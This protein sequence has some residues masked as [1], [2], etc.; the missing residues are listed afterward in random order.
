MNKKFLKTLLLG[1]LMFSFMGVFTACE[2][3][4]DE[5]NNLQNQITANSDA[6]ADIQALLAKGVVIEKVEKNAEGILLTLSDG[7]TQQ[8]TNGANG[9]DGKDAAVWTIGNDGYWY[10]D[11]VK[12]EYKA[13]GTDGKDGQDGQDGKDGQD[14]NDGKDGNDGAMGDKGDVYV[15]NEDGYFHLNGEKTDI[16]WATAGVSAAQTETAV[17]IT[18]A[19][20]TKVTISTVADLK[21]MVFVPQVVVDGVNGI[22]AGALTFNDNIIC[23]PNVTAQYHLNPSSVKETGIDTESLSYVLLTKD[24]LSTRA[25]SNVTATYKEVKDGVLTV[26]VDFNGTPSTGSKIDLIALQAVN[27]AGATITSDY[28]TVATDPIKAEDFYISRKSIIVRDGDNAHFWEGAQKN[29][30]QTAS[31]NAAKAAAITEAAAAT[32]L[33][34]STDDRIITVA[35][36]KTINLNDYVGLCLKSDNNHSVFS[37][38]SD[39]HLNFRYSLV[40]RFIIGGEAGLKVETD[41]QKF[42]KLDGDKV[43]PTTYTDGDNLRSSIGRTPIVKVELLHENTV[44]KTAYIVIEIVDNGPTPIDPEKWT[45]A[46]Y[47]IVLANEGSNPGYFGYTA[48]ICDD[49]ANQITAQN[50]NSVYSGEEV[51]KEEFA[52]NYTFVPNGTRYT[53]EGVTYE[54]SPVVAYSANAGQEATYGLTWTLTAEYIWDNAGVLTPKAQAVYKHNTLNHIVVLNLEANRVIPAIKTVDLNIPGKKFNEMWN[55]D[56]TLGLFNVRVPNV[57]ENTT[58]NCTFIN[59][60]KSLYLEENGVSQDPVTLIQ[61]AFDASVYGSF[62]STIEY[63]FK[64]ATVDTRRNGHFDVE[65]NGK[66]LVWIQGLEKHLIATLNGSEVTLNNAHADTDGDGAVDNFV[67]EEFLNT[68]TLTVTYT[69][70]TSMTTCLKDANG[71]E[72]VMPIPAKDQKIIEINVRYVRPINVNEEAA[73]AFQDGEDFG[74]PG[75]ILEAADVIS[76]VDW[77][78]KAVIYNNMYYGYYGVQRVT[79][80]NSG[81]T[82]DIEAGENRPLPSTI[83]AGIVDAAALADPDLASGLTGLTIDEYFYYKN[84]G[85]VLQDDI[86]INFPVVVTYWWGEVEAGTV[87]VTVKKTKNI[88]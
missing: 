78:G 37:Q 54:T 67:A 28:H 12:T 65:N 52:A 20:G 22:W 27:A 13:V 56:L 41:Q 6:I 45:A 79:V 59:E 69:V 60:I 53:V 76:L 15:P 21:S 24:Y 23:T 64:G 11:G 43:T 48:D 35:Y 2:D 72:R 3:Y 47:P 82:C 10:K 84:N 81:I 87:K 42:I 70:N 26:D 29:T 1:G 83:K 30:A 39:Y 49:E 5:I 38:M 18:N 44:L 16:Q 25:I 46:V 8:I 4:D 9:A 31:L 34:A 62:P 71:N 74:R 86:K 33:L 57:G 61:Q 77:R 85:T 73:D 19:D 51:S 14:G 80:R 7:T 36:D 68:N 50:M 66:S 17:V 32:D 58:T 55:D 40:D 63:V 75:T 88:N